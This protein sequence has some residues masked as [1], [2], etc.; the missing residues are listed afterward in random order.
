ML[1]PAVILS[2]VGAYFG[3]LFIIAWYTSRGSSNATFFLAERSVP[4]YLVAFGMIG[5][6]L[7]G[8]TFI[9]VP[10]AVGKASGLNIQFSY[11]QVVLG[12]LLGYWAIAGVL[13]PLYYRLGLTS[14]YSYLGQRF[15]TVSHKTGSA[16]FI[17]SRSLGSAARL[18]LSVAVLHKFVLEAFGV[19][20]P[21]AVLIFMCII[22]AYTY[23]GGIKT[24]VW[25]DTFQTAVMLAVLVATVGYI[26][27]QLQVGWAQ[28]PQVIADGGYGKIF[29]WDDFWSDPNH[30]V[31]QF[32]GGAF[33]ALCMTGLDQDMMQ[34]NLTCKN[35][36]ESQKNIFWFSIV[37]VFV[38]MLFLALG[39]LLYVYTKTIPDYV[40]PEKP[41]Y[42]FPDIALHHLPT[43][44]GL[45]F[46]LGLVAT[47]HSG[48]DSAIAALTTSFCMDFLGFDKTEGNESNRTRTRNIVFA[49]FS[50]LMMLLAVLFYELNNPSVIT[51]L[52]KIAT[53][54][55][56]PLLGLFAFGLLTKRK[57]MD[58][59]TPI[60]C[61]VA[62]LICF[63]LANNSKEF[64]GGYVLGFELLPLNGLL[65]FVGLWLGS[66]AVTQPKEQAELFEQ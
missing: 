29:F 12:Y 17:L 31:K 19:P 48:V 14:I 27:S 32:V 30:F 54:T 16:F 11:L 36:G 57:V 51:F 3:A 33:I 13:L 64:L 62:P 23:K 21:V 43:V 60:I 10:G 28:V 52:F 20:F 37:L 46:V 65:T 45:L 63:L 25:T 9:S 7:S 5:G 58:V 8:V 47:S 26:I 4:W 53:Y 34:K 38:N 2:V 61:I 56:G 1:T 6:S 18:Y 55:Y 66:L 40:L 59:I 39:A 49:S 22:W 44:V 15:G 24:I 41:D 50:V 35:I 42:L